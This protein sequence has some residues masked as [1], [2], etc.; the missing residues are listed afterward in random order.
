M[1]RGVKSAEAQNL[2]PEEAAARKAER[3]RIQE[4]RDRRAMLLNVEKSVKQART[5]LDDGDTN[6]HVT[7]L[8][9]AVTGLNA[10]AKTVRLNSVGATLN[11]VNSP[12]AD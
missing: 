6:G 3:K 4:T 1:P 8:D 10:Y 5:A 11:G 9:V 7:W 12:G 2:T